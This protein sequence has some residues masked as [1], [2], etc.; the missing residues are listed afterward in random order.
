[1]KQTDS[2]STASHFISSS[3]SRFLTTCCQAQI[4]LL[5]KGTFKIHVVLL[6]L[7]LINTSI[8]YR[9]SI[10]AFIIKFALLNNKASILLFYMYMYAS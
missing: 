5:L 1:M 6:L 4:F 3:L 8:E 9:Y 2:T 10:V 7:E